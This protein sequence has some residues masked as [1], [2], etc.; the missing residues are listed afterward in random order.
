MK[1]LPTYVGIDPSDPDMPTFGETVEG[2]LE[3][4]TVTDDWRDGDPMYIYKLAEVL[5]L[6]NKPTWVKTGRK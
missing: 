6:K 2:L 5:I 4:L 1:Q 3:N